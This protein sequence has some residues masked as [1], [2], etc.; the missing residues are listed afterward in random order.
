MLKKLIIT[1]IFTVFSG[2]T[3]YVYSQQYSL[4]GS[5]IYNF[6]SKGIGLGFRSEIPIERIQLL[7]GISIAPQIS[8]FPWFNDV[9][10][11]YIGSS[12]HLGVYKINRW[13]FYGLANV[14]YNGWI[15][16]GDSNDNN[17][18]FSNLAAEAGIGVTQW[19]CRWRPYSELRLN[20]IGTEPNFR[21]GMLY[22]F[23]CKIRGQ[24]PC[25]KIPPQP[26]FEQE[27]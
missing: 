16:Y 18:Q 3:I 5:V 25:S 21:I 12:I 2:I 1:G 4:G 23:N 6:K 11:F 9:S 22:T 7:E 15:N 20:F 26:T 27:Q 19:K 24:V 13:L 14:S 8:Y 17:A 10:E